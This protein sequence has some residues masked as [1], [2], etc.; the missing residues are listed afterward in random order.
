MRPPGP[1]AAAA[2]D[3]RALAAL[4]AWLAMQAAETR[5]EWALE[6]LPG[7]HALSTSF[8]AQSAVALH[9]STRLQ[10]DLPII[11]VDTGYL[12]PET[13]RF[14]DELVARL[15]LN[16]KVEQPELSPARMEALHGRLW[17]QGIDGLNL[18]N[19]MRKVQPM[20]RALDALGVRT[21][22]AGIRRTQSTSRAK[23]DFLE[24]RDGRWKLHPIADWSD[25]DVGHYLA[26]HRLPYHP[27]WDQGYVSIGD[28]HTTVRWH[29]GMRE[30]DTRF[31]GLKRECGLHDND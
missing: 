4:N 19:R 24:L 14:A 8:G 22:I 18:Y 28:T 11:L 7:G 26:D 16:L 5:V 29:E 6:S 30:E 10:P 27:L 15:K 12:F 31:H 1:A 3:P 21:W 9:L 2:E 25:H 17:E 23:I 20:K 13:Y